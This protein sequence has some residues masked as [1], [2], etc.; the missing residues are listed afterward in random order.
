MLGEAGLPR[1]ISINL[2]T[3]A[4]KILLGETQQSSIDFEPGQDTPQTVNRIPER[5]GNDSERI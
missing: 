1:A 2:S 4:S 3:M 5:V